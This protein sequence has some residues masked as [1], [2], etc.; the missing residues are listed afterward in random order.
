MSR[1]KLKRKRRVIKLKERLRQ[2]DFSF[3]F[4]LLGFGIFL[5]A[6]F[7]L[8]ISMSKFE[9]YSGIS[10]TPVPIRVVAIIAELVLW[11]VAIGYFGEN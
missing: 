8:A 11:V 6:L 10:Y 7:S 3:I 4:D 5:V 1:N 9:L 2:T